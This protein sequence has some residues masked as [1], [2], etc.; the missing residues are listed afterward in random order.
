MKMKDKIKADIAEQKAKKRYAMQIPIKE[1]K[2][3]EDAVSSEISD[4]HHEFPGGCEM[5]TG[6]ASSNI[7]DLFTQFLEEKGVEITK[8]AKGG[9]E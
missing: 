9:K 2:D 3:L 7:I 4:N 8:E 5:K 6:Q 1:L